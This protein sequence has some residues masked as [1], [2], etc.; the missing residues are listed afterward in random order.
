VKSG[1]TL[2]AIAQRYQTSVKEL[3]QWN[4]LQSGSTLKVGQKLRIGALPAS[5]SNDEALALQKI[6]Y[7]V[8]SGDSLSVIADRYNIDVADIR[9]WN[10][11][12]SDSI[13]IKP[14]QQLKL[15]IT[16]TRIVQN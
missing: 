10:N 4:N 3:A 1:D 15:F 16:D 12:R 6:G 9:E 7:K 2:W 13:I 11:L 14:G 5:F 8:R